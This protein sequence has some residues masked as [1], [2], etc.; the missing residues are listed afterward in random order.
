[1]GQRPQ[2]GGY[3][4]GG[5]YGQRPSGPPGG[6]Y[7]QRPQGVGYGGGGGYGQRPSGSPGGGYGQRPQGG[8]AYGMRPGGRP[9]FGAPPRAGGGFGGRPAGGPPRRGP[10]GGRAGSPPRQ[11]LIPR[12]ALME[13][14]RRYKAALPLP[15]PDIHLVMSEALGIE[16]RKVFF[17]INLV[18]QKLRLPKLDYPKRK[19]AVTPD[20]IM[21]VQSLY[22]PYLPLPP[23]GI[24]KIIAKQLHMDEWRVHVAIGLIRKSRNMGRWNEERDDLPAQMKAD[25]D[26]LKQKQLTETPAGVLVEPPLE[27]PVLEDRDLELKEAAP[28]KGTKSKTKKVSPPE[29]VPSSE[30][31]AGLDAPLSSD[32]VASSLTSL[33]LAEQADVPVEEVK[34]RRRRKAASPS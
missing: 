4:G 30:G 27:A 21:A 31:L 17:G 26:A 28:S 11:P 12:E 16:D 5:G 14:E 18:R 23:I 9:G 3:G 33:P 25:L 10:M 2:G 7:G 13:I 22:E 34:I 20:Q 1:Y 6:G 24:H 19:L 15:N 32:A 29:T 8:G